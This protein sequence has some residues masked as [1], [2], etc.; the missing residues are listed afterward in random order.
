MAAAILSIQSAVS[1]GHVGNS[2]AVFPLQRLGMEVWPVATVQ[3]SNHPGYGHRAGQVLSGAHVR[4]L[5][6]GIAACGVLGRCTALL[7][8]YLGDPSVADALQHSAD[9][10]RRANP[11]ALYCCDPVIG[12]QG[13]GIYVDPAIPTLLRTRLL[14]L[15]DI[16]TPNQFELEVLTGRRVLTLDDA[17]AAAAALRGSMRQGAR[18]LVTSLQSADTPGDE[19]DVLAQDATGTWRVRTPKLPIAANGTGDIVAALF[20]FHILRTGSTAAALSA[21]VSAVFGVLRRTMDAGSRE[22]LIVAAQQ[23]FIRPTRIFQAGQV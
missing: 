7:S 3:F 14:P 23:E 12:D 4:D 2:A 13:P 22:L 8:G 5:V 21:A 17:M 19:V 18:V 1:Y 20:L 16:A 10:V 9:L 11:Q 6:D 15:A